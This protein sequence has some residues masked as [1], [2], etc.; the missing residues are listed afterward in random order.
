VAEKTVTLV[1]EDSERGTWTVPAEM[2]EHATN[3]TGWHRATKTE[4]KA[5]AA[6]AT[7][8]TKG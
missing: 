3:G 1:H 4:A 5:A 2:E 8:D 6:A 7:T